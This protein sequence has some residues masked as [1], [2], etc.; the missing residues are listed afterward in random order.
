MHSKHLAKVL[1]TFIYAVICLSQ[2]V[3]GFSIT[4]DRQTHRK[5]SHLHHKRSGNLGGNICS[6]QS[7]GHR[8][9]STKSRDSHPLISAT[10]PWVHAAEHS[11]I[12]LTCHVCAEHPYKVW[13][14]KDGRHLSRSS[15]RVR[16]HNKRSST[17]PHST[18][19]GNVGPSSTTELKIKKF[20]ESDFGNYRCNIYANATKEEA[21]SDIQVAGQPYPAVFDLPEEW[22]DTTFK[23]SWRVNSSISSPIVDY[24]LEFRR[25]SAALTDWIVVNIPSSSSTVQLPPSKVGVR[26]RAEGP[27]MGESHQEYLL[28]GLSKGHNYE[29]RV[30]SRNQYG[31]SLDSKVF[32]F[33]TFNYAGGSDNHLTRQSPDVSTRTLP[34]TTTTTTQYNYDVFDEEEVIYPRGGGL[35]SNGMPSHTS[36]YSGYDTDDDFVGNSDEVM[37]ATS[38]RSQQGLVAAVGHSSAPKGLQANLSLTLQSLLLTTAAAC[39]LQ[40]KQLSRVL[41]CSSHH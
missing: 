20:R 5:H 19:G 22:S 30:R 25:A 24:Q 3:I 2:D 37:S 27:M 14:S 4:G 12:V 6:L 33:R 18:K 11:T 16:Q 7:G 9:F 1:F 31:A 41:S 17:S 35:G 21:S 32:H 23:L 40:T 38:R 13:W 26:G 36:S 39:I 29:A 15:H 8:R 10:E 28:R 34:T